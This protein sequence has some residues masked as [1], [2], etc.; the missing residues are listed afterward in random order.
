MIWGS[1]KYIQLSDLE[2][3]MATEQLKIYRLPVLI[4]FQ[5]KLFMEEIGD[6]RIGSEIRRLTDSILNKE[7]FP[8][9]WKE[10]IL[11]PIHKKVN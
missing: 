1:L 2:I 9:L 7:E 10:S 3:M 4:K 6:R 11:V 5:H 8:E